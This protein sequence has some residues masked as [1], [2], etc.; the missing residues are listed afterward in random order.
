MFPVLFSIGNISIS[1]FGAFLALGFLFS[2]FLVWRLT[3]AWDLDEEKILDVTLLTFLGGLLGA[4]LYF[5][6]ENLSFFG[7][8]LLK[9]LLIN[10]Y[11]G[12]SFWGGFLG[13]WLT[14]HILARRFKI[15]FWQL[16][17]IA[18]VGFL[19]GLILSEVGCFLGGC[20]IGIPANV[21]LAVPMVGQL[22]KRWPIQAIEALLLSLVLL[23]IWSAAT[24]FHQRGK[25]VGMALI[26]L[27][28]IKLL[29]EPLKQ[30]GKGYFFDSILV[31]LG[32]TIFYK[33]TR[34]NILTDLKRGFQF[35]AS[36]TTKADSRKTLL[37]HIN[38]T[39]YNQKTAIVWKLKNVKKYLRRLNVKFSYKNH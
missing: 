4:R 35:I 25:I 21:F 9:W 31:I 16:S 2:V 39:W 27:G 13:G 11:P 15:D 20:N 24:H 1:S 3:R 5:I 17:D 26:Y 34:R 28:L 36:L 6:L 23:K 30:A 8:S 18:A 12:F 22:G 38:K 19:G 37:Q 33:A 10:K 32:V 14:L 29:L 7:F